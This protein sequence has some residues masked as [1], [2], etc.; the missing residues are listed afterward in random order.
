V[1]A[2]QNARRYPRVKAPKEILVTW[3]SGSQM[4]VSRA[5][6]LGLGGLFARTQ[7]PLA[8]GA[9]IEVLFNTPEGEVQARATVRHSVTGLGMGLEIVSMEHE[10]RSRLDR[11]LKKLT[12]E[13]KPVAVSS[14]TTDVGPVPESGV[15]AAE[16]GMVVDQM[17]S[18]ATKLVRFARDRFQ[19]RLDYSDASIAEVERVLNELQKDFTRKGHDA[20]TTIAG[21]SNHFG[22][23]IGEVLRRKHGGKWRA[24]IA[25]LS[26]PAHGVEV[27]ELTFAPSR[28]V[29]L[30]LTEGADYNVKALYEKFEEDIARSVASRNEPSTECETATANVIV[31]NCATN[32]IQDARKRFDFALEYTEAS[33]DLLEEIFRRISDLLT[34]RATPTQRLRE[35]EKVMLKAEGPLNYGAYLGEVMCKNLGGHWQDTIP[36]SDIRRIVVVIDGRYFDPLEY[37]RV[38]IKDP[39]E[40]SVKTFYFDAKKVSQ[41][42]GVITHSKR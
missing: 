21:L 9:V 29:Y 20:R 18:F 33:L 15:S 19:L 22:A 17:Q 35:E 41:F 12:R 6:N 5:D 2:K 38:A 24:N 40:F 37:A 39:R 26:P 23:Y 42:D 28:N 16:R 27:G 31:R 7:H 11:W 30:R 25:N 36:G 8:V 34:D 4:D 14:E 3:K 1:T 32:A 10:H 13:A